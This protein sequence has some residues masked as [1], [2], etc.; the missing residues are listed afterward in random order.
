[1][2]TLAPAA[3]LL[4]VED[5]PNDLELTLRALQKHNIA[6]PIHVAKD[7]DEALEYLFCE[8][9]YA[10]RHPAQAPRV[11]FL[12]LKLPKVDGMEVLRRIKSDE[13][14]RAI[15]VVMLTS[16]QQERDV[17]E[18]YRLGVN[19]YIVK[20]VDFEQFTEAV[21]QLGFYWLLLNQPPS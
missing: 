21:R 10:S 19:S 12:D 7:G 20:P 15:P 9:R 11:I 2:M 8:G 3:E 14:T 6:N 4:I 18:S 5:N 17:I 1:M 16:S 13:R